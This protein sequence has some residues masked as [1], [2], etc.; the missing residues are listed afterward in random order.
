MEDYQVVDF[1]ERY[2]KKAD[3]RGRGVVADGYVSRWISC[4]CHM[5]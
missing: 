2:G 5:Y 4:L 3:G 1:W